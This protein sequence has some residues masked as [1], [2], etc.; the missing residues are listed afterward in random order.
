VIAVTFGS[1]P[2]GPLKLR[3]PFGR[4]LPGV[5]ASLLVVCVGCRALADVVIVRSS[6][7]APYRQADAVFTRR[8]S[9]PGCKVR[10]VLVKELADSGI[11][12]AISTTDTVVAIGTPAAVWLHSQLPE[13]VELVYCMVTSAED[14]GLLKGSPCWGVSMEV[15]EGEQFKLIAEALPSAHSVGLLYHSDTAAG[16][17]MLQR[18]R[19]SLP[20]GWQ[21]NAVAVNDFAS[22]AEAVD[23]LIQRNVDVIWT[24]AD[25]KL[26]DAAAVRELLTAALRAKIPVWGFSP[27]FV[28]AG[29]LI[30]VGVDPESQANQASDLIA[31]I[32]QNKAS[33]EKSQ[34]PTNYQIAVNLIVAE[35][36]NIQIAADLVNRAKF[37]FQ[38]EK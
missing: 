9:G 19:D 13:G 23:A 14:A 18:F 28:R 1:M 34:H 38:G 22:M 8:L 25:F 27:A 12:S 3:L 4:R 37:V 35:Q 7:A 6:D 32:R 26:Y 20:G 29:A 16:R 10:S 17:E 21:V 5:I 15:S 24:Q 36:L 2:F 33:T 11:G 30:G 31:A